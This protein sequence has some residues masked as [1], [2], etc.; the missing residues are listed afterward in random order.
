MNYL[1]VEL[2]LA[3]K[4]DHRT[5]LIV[6]NISWGLGFNHE[7]DLAVLTH[8]GYLWEVEIKMTKSDLKRDKKKGHGHYSNRIARLYFS[9]P[10]DMDGPEI[11]EHIPPRAGIVIVRNSQIRGTRIIQAHADVV[12]APVRNRDARALDKAEQETMH[13]LAAMRIWSLKE[14]IHSMTTR[15]E[16]KKE[17]AGHTRIDAAN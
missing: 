7:L 1:D 16:K 6:P 10:E 5:N 9:Y 4:F 2:A 12:R 3:R 14:H 17:K 11:R 8:S 15:Y 13:K